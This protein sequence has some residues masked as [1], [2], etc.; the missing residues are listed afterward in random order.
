MYEFAKE[1]SLDVKATGNKST[2]DRTHI[3]LLKAPGIMT[4]GVSTLSS[5]SD[6]SE[7]CNRLR[8]LLLEKK[9]EVN[10]I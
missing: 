3:K 1:M 8:L 2:R 10:L 6:D 5:P 4:S 7:L 9:L